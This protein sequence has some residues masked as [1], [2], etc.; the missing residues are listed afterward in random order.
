MGTVIVSRNSDYP[1]V[2]KRISNIFL[3]LYND[4][5]I[6]FVDVSLFEFVYYSKHDSIVGQYG[7]DQ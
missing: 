1:R 5:I 4:G 3:I 2:L 6:Y 7:N